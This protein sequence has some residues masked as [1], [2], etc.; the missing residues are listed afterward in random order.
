MKSN[1]QVH[2]Y[3][4]CRQKNQKKVREWQKIHLHDVLD[5]CYINKVALRH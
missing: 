4:M 3:S 2:V 5:L 1:V